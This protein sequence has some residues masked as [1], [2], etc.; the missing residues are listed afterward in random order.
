[1]RFYTFAKLYGNSVLVRG[2]DDAKGGHFQERVPFRPTLFLPSK[3][4]TEYT[5]LEGEYVTPI[6]PGT[7]KE[8]RQFID[9]YSGISGTKVFGMERFLYQYL[10]KEFDENIEYDSSKIKMWSLDIETASENGFPKPELAE[11]EVLLILSLI[12]I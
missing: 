12:H 2:W 6:E 8:C 7:I 3:K 9:D 4:P 11:E 10:A 5:T 1:M